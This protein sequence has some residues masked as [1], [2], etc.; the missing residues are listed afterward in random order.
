MRLIQNTMKHMMHGPCGLAKKDSPCMEDG[1]C[2]RHFPKRFVEN[3]TI[4]EDSYPVYR[5]RDDGKTIMKSGIDLDNRYVVPHNRY[6]LMRYGAHINVEWCNQSRSIKYLFK[7]VNKGHDHV[8]ASFYKSAT[9]DAD[10]D[11]H[12]EVSMY[13][14]C[15]YISPCEAAWRIFEYNVHYRDPSVVRLGFHLPNE[16]PVIFRDDENLED[17]ARK[18]SV[19]ESMFLEWFEANKSYPE[20]RSLTYA[21][22]PTKFIWKAKERKWSPRKSH[23][24]IGRIFF[25]PPRSGENYYLRLLLNYAKGPKS[26]EEIRTIDGVLHSSFRDAC[27]ARGLLDDDKEYVDAIKEASHWGSGVYLRKLFA[28]LLFSNSME[29]PEHVWE[30]IWHLLSDDILQKQRRIMKNPGKNSLFTMLNLSQKLSS[31]IFVLITCLLI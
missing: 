14:N 16:Q 15:R 2:I 31:S 17:V 22:F 1:K 27:Y 5:R 6:L 29:R 24:V 13:Y 4:D 25:V 28:I 30:K 10:K 7:Y 12:D 18:A 23:A 8:T 20:A 19:K 3:T 9:E 21:E 26:Y 11:E